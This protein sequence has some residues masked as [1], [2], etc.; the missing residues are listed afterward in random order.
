[1]GANAHHSIFDYK[2]ALNPQGIFVMVGGGM[3]RILQTVL[4]LPFLSRFGKKRVR[5]FIA[6]VNTKDLLFLKDLLEA[7]K[8][9]PVID[10]SYALSEVAEAIR[11]REEGHAQGKVVIAIDPNS[12]LHGTNFAAP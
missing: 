8:I 3:G 12:R 2:R 10:R 7:G 6:K 11:Y 1:L 5:F 4:L 9:S